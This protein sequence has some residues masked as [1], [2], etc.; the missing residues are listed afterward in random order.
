M[1]HVYISCALTPS[2]MA[3]YTCALIYALSTTSSTSHAPSH[4][5]PWLR[6]PAPFPCPHPWHVSPSP[7]I[8]GCTCPHQAC[9]LVHTMCHLMLS[10]HACMPLSMLHHALQSHPHHMCPRALPAPSSMLAVTCT[11]H[12]WLCAFVHTPTVSSTQI[13]YEI[14]VLCSKYYVS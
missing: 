3:V 11:I 14:R 6:M 8:H 10:M 1:P 9:T 7:S 5:C 4:I 12:P 2:S 13:Q